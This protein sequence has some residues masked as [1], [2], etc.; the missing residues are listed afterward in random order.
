MG[1]AQHIKKCA[2][3]PDAV[4][5]MTGLCARAFFGGLDMSRC[6]GGTFCMLRLFSSSVSFALYFSSLSGI[7]YWIVDEVLR[8]KSSGDLHLNNKG[9]ER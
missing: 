7:V 5:C 1:F 4:R 9:Q 2:S 6:S 3:V 8:K